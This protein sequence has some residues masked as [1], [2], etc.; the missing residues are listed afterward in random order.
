MAHV[1][2]IVYG[3][4]IFVSMTI[5]LTPVV[6]SRHRVALVREWA[7]NRATIL[8]G[9]VLVLAT[10][11]IIL[12]AMQVAQ[13]SYIVP[14]REVSV[15]IGAILGVRLLNEGFGRERIAGAALI[16]LGILTIAILG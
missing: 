7:I 8:I 3:Y 1:H 6:L 2:P 4:L 14:L 15:L 12:S 11:L 16:L 13:V 10:Y 5:G 9:G